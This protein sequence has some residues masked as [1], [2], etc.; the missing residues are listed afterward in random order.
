MPD[1]VQAVLAD[2]P[3]WEKRILELALEWP[4]LTEAQAR[5]A[6]RLQVFLLTWDPFEW[7]VGRQGAFATSTSRSDGVGLVLYL[8]LWQALR[9]AE[10]DPDGLAGV[11]GRL[12]ESV[13]SVATEHEA[14]VAAG[15]YPE[16]VLADTVPDLLSR[17]PAVPALGVP[18]VSVVAEGWRVI[19]FDVLEDLAQDIFGPADLDRSPVA[20][21]P[22]P[23]RRDGCQGCGGAV[24]AFPDGLKEAQAGI[25]P[26]HRAEALRITT[27][28]LERAKASNPAGWEALLEAGQRLTEP[29]LPNGLG[30]RLVAAASGP[31]AGVL[32]T[33]AGSS[34][35]V[36]S[37]AGSSGAVSSVGG[38]SVG[39]SSVGGSSV[40][41]S[42]VG[43]SSV[44]GSSVAGSSGAGLEAQVALVLEAAGLMTGLPDPQ[45]PLGGHL[46]P[47]RTWLEGL[48]SVLAG[49]GLEEQSHAV[50]A[51]AAELLAVAPASPAQ[52]DTAETAA[53]AAPAAP[54]APPKPEPIR[55]ARISRNG[56]C[57]CG[58]GKKYKYCCGR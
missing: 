47:V 29:H 56:P 39:G 38:S 51:A 13:L 12:G 18:A 25:C 11:L 43:G 26:F 53:T 20:F 31:A 58:S 41:G 48:P 15:G 42:S 45:T 23:E 6:A 33:G 50:T 37:G 40:G 14:A 1:Q 32:P 21:G 27:A 4:G 44:G 28:R 22:P 30:P 7:R 17:A 2:A 52:A 5:T 46:A 36:S 35:A 9:Q 19:Q 49:Q 10:S 24:V 54:A 55:V 16:G 34:G 57:P 8:P 3:V